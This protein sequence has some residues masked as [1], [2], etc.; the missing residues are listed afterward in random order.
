[1]SLSKSAFIFIPDIS[2][3]TKFVNET[4]ISHSLHIISE[5]LELIINA[6]QLNLTVSEIE[7]DAILFYRDDVPEIQ[8]IIEQCQ[9]TF[10]AFHNHIQRYDTERICR[11]GACETAFNLSLKFVV[12][13]GS[14]QKMKIKNHEKL[15]GS[16]LILAH[17]FLKNN[18]SISEYILISDQFNSET[19]LKAL[20][21][22]EWAGIKRGLGVFE[23]LGEIPY[24]YIPM[25]QLQDKVELPKLVSIPELSKFKLQQEISIDASVD[26]IY[27]NFTNF[28]KRVK[29]NKEIREIILQNEKINKAGALHTCLVGSHTL[30]IESIGRLEDNDKIIYGERLN[31]FKGLRDIIS[32][33]TFEKKSK[34]T[35]VIVDL[36]FK[37]GGG[38]ARLIKPFIKRMLIAQTKHGL[39]RLKIIS[40]KS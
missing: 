38:F 14:L 19:L 34:Q 36:D 33:Y 4:E 35:H 16:D 11:C 1:M 25:D 31:K 9:K 37:V 39:K 15:H 21:R 8:D 40:E 7:G 12:H 20:Q 27:E 18:I 26:T 23:N 5:L 6:D 13:A 22:Y 28:E 30:D 10:I 17:R 32:I 24:S 29:W 3:F 2:G